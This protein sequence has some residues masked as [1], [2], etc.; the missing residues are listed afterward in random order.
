M[1]IIRT[2]IHKVFVR[3]ANREDPDQSLIWVCAVCL[4]LFWQATSVQNLS[5][6]TVP[7]VKVGSRQVQSFYF[8]WS[9]HVQCSSN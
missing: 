3:I 2:E 1:L 5:T 8:V 4:G 9:V 6:F 7:L